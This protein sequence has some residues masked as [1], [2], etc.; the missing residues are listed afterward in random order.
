MIETQGRIADRTITFALYIGVVGAV[1]WLS[2][3]IID[4]ALDARFYYFY[5]LKWENSIDAYTAAG[6]AFPEFTGSDHEEYM[7]MLL[8]LFASS[9]I[10]VPR[11]NTTKPYV[12]QV[13]R[14]DPFTESRAVFLL[15]LH[16]R[17]FVFNLPET[18]FNRVDNFID[19]RTD[20]N[21]GIF[22]GKFNSEEHS[23]DSLLEL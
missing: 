18:T 3:K 19:G 15:A 23:F 16:D 2:L 4:Y 17:L 1:L 20:M 22:L 6:G 14:M 13:L 5:L 9:N 12:Y 11:S 7:N 21:Q 8:T 10:S